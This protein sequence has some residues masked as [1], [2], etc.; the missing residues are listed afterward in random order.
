[1][2]KITE[3]RNAKYTN[4]DGWIECEIKH[5]ELEGGD[6]IPYHIN[7]K[8]DHPF[9][10]MATL[11]SSAVATNPTAY[12]PLTQEEI[13]AET[14][15]QVRMLRNEMLSSDVDPIVTNPLRWDAMSSDEQTKVKNYRTSLL[16]ITK[17]SGFPNSIT[18]PTKDF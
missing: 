12:T 18:W 16:D 3:V 9:I 10:D 4:A 7:P 13:D 17:Q 1:M 14:A 11:A 2:L 5:D 8:E 15:K 6:W